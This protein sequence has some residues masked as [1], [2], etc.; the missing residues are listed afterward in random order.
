MRDDKQLVSDILQH[1][2]RL[3]RQIQGRTRNDL[4]TDEL[5]IDALL[6]NLAVIGEAATRLSTDFK[7]LHP[8]MRWKEIA[9]MRNWIVHAYWGM[10]YS[11][12]WKTATVD[13]P[14]LREYLAQLA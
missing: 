11:T 6:H 14:I 9:G 5:L 3:M 1:C 2:E 10:D 13:V 7:C 8:S 4:E 12:V